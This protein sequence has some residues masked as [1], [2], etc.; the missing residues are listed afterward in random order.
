VFYGKFDRRPAVII[1]AR[2]AADVSRVASL[3]RETGLELAVRGGGHSL[4]G[5]GTSDGGIVL[6]LSDMRGL[7]I[8]AQAR[9]A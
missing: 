7:E 3:A 8:D 4:A 1:R 2:D 6:D 5:H 9:T